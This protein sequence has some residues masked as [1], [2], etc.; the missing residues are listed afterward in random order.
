M[1]VIEDDIDD[2]SEPELES[3][4]DFQALLEYLRNV[5][6]FD[7]AGYKRAGLMRRIQR[8]MQLVG[9]AGFSDYQDFLEVYPDEFSSLFNAVLIN[10]TQFFRDPSLWEDMTTDVIPRLLRTKPPGTPIRVW[11]AGCASGEETYTLAMVLAEALG[12]AEFS[13]RVKIYGTDIDE[14]ALAQAR[15][16]TYSAKAVESISSDLRARYLEKTP[17]GDYVFTGAVRRAV[18]FGRHNLLLDAP[19]SRL[20]L[21]GC[22][23]TLMYFHTEAQAQILERFHFAL[24]DDGFLFLGRAEMLFTHAHLFLPLQDKQRIFTKVLRDRRFRASYCSWKRNEAADES[25]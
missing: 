5:R 16:A 21:L 9:L 22:R 13:E 23:N 15:L 7:F 8:R 17:E 2:I 24:N 18:V 19:I 4:G 20:D 25:Q 14:E 12:P 11:S 6:G 1:E 10:V 3:N